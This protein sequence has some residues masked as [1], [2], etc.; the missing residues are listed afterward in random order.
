MKSQQKNAIPFVWTG[1]RSNCF[2]QLVKYYQLVKCGPFWGTRSPSA[3]ASW[4][5][6]SASLDEGCMRRAGSMV[7]RNRCKKVLY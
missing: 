6:T 4:G 7:N 5:S 2:Y 1:N 3:G